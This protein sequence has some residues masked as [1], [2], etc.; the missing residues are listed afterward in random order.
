MSYGPLLAEGLYLANPLKAFRVSA[1]AGVAGRIRRL[2]QSTSRV[3]AAVIFVDSKSRDLLGAALIAYHLEKRGVRCHLEP[4]EAWRACVGAWKPDFILFN[5]LSAAHLEGFTRDCKEWGVLIGMLP[6][7]GIFYVDGTL[8]YNSKKHYPDIHC[9]RAFAWN[10]IHREALVA[11]GFCEDPA[12][13][14][15][16][17][18]PRFDFYK[19]PWKKVLTGN[20]VKRDRPVILM[21]ANFPVAFFKELPDKSADDFFGQFSHMPVFR[22][23]RQIIDD[24]WTARNEFHA[25]LKAIVESGNYHVILRPHPR[26]SPNLYLEWLEAF[27]PEQRRH[28]EFLPKAPISELILNV[29]LEVSC[30]NCTTALEAWIAGKPTI[31]LTFRK[32]PFFYTPEVG[33]LLPECDD[34]S[35]IVAMIKENLQHP[36]Q[37]EY[38][39]ARE[40]HLRKWV[41][42]VDGRSAERVADEIAGAIASRGRPK[43]I[44]L[45]FGN[46][47]RGLKLRIARL[48]GEPYNF[49]PML[50]LRRLTKGDLGKP[51]IRYR[52]Y[53]KAIRPSEE[54]RALEMIR[55][56]DR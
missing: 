8:E 24:N 31:S 53:L 45:D 29:D 4:L 10:E 14:I 54:R 20:S 26:E 52:S 3:P 46:W 32:N 23:Y 21:N 25:Y 5:H 27:T 51:T 6:N 35:Q 15:T 11:H 47:R 37:A 43:R 40:K 56:A 44:R 2:V 41:H 17:G 9:D 16:V 42:L 50:F 22:P 38:K 19:D 48:F 36:E 34:P 39:E 7:E 33:E 55:K 12:A 18:V 13:V 28:I 49:S 1:A 30:E